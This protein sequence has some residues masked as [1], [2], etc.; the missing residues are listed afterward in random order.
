MRRTLQG[1]TASFTSSFSS[2]PAFCFAP[3]RMFLTTILRGMSHTDPHAQLLSVP[4]FSNVVNKMNGPGVFCHVWSAREAILSEAHSTATKTRFCRN[5]SHSSLKTFSL[6]RQM[7]R[8]PTHILSQNFQKLPSA[9]PENRYSMPRYSEDDRYL[10]K[11][12]AG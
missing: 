2:V 4:P 6:Y 8:D 3:P 5:A 10:A 1:G 11:P 12:I 7:V 9:L